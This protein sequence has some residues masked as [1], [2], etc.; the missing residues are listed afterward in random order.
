M[1]KVSVLYPNSEGSTFDMGYYRDSPNYTNAQ[2]LIQVSE[3]RF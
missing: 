2:P 1:I 3:V